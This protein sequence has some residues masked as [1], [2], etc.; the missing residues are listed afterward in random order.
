MKQKRLLRL[1]RGPHG[2]AGVSGT[3]VYSF[4]EFKA[5]VKYERTRSDRNGSK[6]SIVSFRME[7]KTSRNQEEIMHQVSLFSR[8][9][10][11]IGVGE[12][13]QIAVLLPDTLKEGAAVFGKKVVGE[14]GKAECGSIGFDVYEYPEN[15]LYSDKERSAGQDDLER[16]Y[17]SIRESIEFLF[18]ERIP[19]WK[20]VLDICGASGL[21]I[22]SSPLFLL[23]ALHIKLVSP[24]PVFFK[25]TRVGYKGVPFD[26]WKFRTMKRDNN[27]AFHGNYAHNFIVD[28]DVP[29]EKLD[30]VDPRIILG[31]RVIRKSCMD[32]LPQLWNVLKGD[33]SLVGPRPC[34]PY[35]A[36]EYLR[37]HTHRFDVLPG[38]SGLWQVS[39]KNKLTFRQMVRLD[40]AYCLNMSLLGDLAI[41]LRTPVAIARMCLEA[42]V[43]KL[44]GKPE[45]TVALPMAKVSREAMR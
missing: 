24:G 40:I 35:E 28:G 32:E 44:C 14:L 4:E 3:N 7:E 12:E 26:F 36:K 10:D 22:L 30:S 41:L 17:D 1:N 9:I 39:G 16:G 43:N 37:W 2:K 5:L 29:M 33:M 25:Q 38:L 27:Q 23:L 8:S 6:F 18:V 15:W 45:A 11:C 19:V 20:R 21:L 34:I 13:G 42:G 31:G